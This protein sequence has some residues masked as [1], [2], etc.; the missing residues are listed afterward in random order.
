MPSPEQGR[1][2]EHECD[3]GRSWRKSERLRRTSSL[4]RS[5]PLS[6]RRAAGTRS[7]AASCCRPTSSPVRS[8]D[9]VAAAR[10]RRSAS[11]KLPVVA[12]AIGL[13]WPVLAYVCGLYALDDLRSW[14]SGVGDAPRLAV[15]SLLI[16]WPVFG[17]LT[18]LDAGTP[19]GRRAE[20]RGHHRRR[21][22]D[23]PRRRARRPAPLAR[24][25]R[26]HADPRLR[27]GRAAARAAPAAPPGARAGP[28]RLH[29]RRRP[30]ARPARHPAPRHARLA[31][32]T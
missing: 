28:G 2:L 8:P 14:A 13:G 31:A 5:Y 18:A 4:R 20:R 19:G 30:R 16:S 27:R 12:L 7:C 15:T 17:L 26:A 25:A 9:A 11:S 21:R 1:G 22:R 3:I 24:P 23:R 29:R 6:P 10:R 32:A